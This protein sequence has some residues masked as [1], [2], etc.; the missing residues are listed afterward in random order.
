MNQRHFLLILPFFFF[1]SAILGTAQTKVEHQ[2]VATSVSTD[3]RFF[4]YLT[5]NDGFSRNSIHA[6]LQDKYGFMWFLLWDGLYRFDGK[7]LTHI[8]ATNFQKQGK[9]R[10]INTFVSDGNGNIWMGTTDNIVIWDAAQQ[11]VIDFKDKTEEGKIFAGAVNKLKRDRYNN[12]W[13][14]NKNRNIVIYNQQQGEF[15]DISDILKG[16]DIKIQNIYIDHQDQVWITTSA[17]GVFQ[18]KG[19]GTN[20]NP[21]Y[22]NQWKLFENPLFKSFEDRNV[23][24]MY[25]DSHNHYWLGTKR[26]IFRVAPAAE[27]KA[28]VVYQFENWDKKNKHIRISDFEE[29]NHT[30]YGAT[31]QGLFTF[32]FNTEKAEWKLPDYT[33]ENRLNDKSLTSICID[34]ENGMWIA[35]Y[36]GGVNYMHPTNKNFVQF[37]DLNKNIQGHVISGITEDKNGNIWMAVEDNG[38][39]LWNRKT[40]TIQNFNHNSQTVYH[41]SWHNVQSIY[42]DGNFLY[43]GMF[44]GGLDIV[45]LDNYSH[46]NLNQRNTHPSALPNNIYSFHKLNEKTL[47][48][49]TLNGLFEL[50]TQNH[51]TRRIK[52]IEGKVNCI[53]QDEAGDL[54]VSTLSEG[55]YWHQQTN[56]QW[57]QFK[58]SS[59]DS[60]QNI[61]NSITTIYPLNPSIFVGTQGNGL[62]VFNKTTQTAEPVAPKIFRKSII[63]NIIQKGEIL[64]ITTNKGLF[65]YNITNQQTK[66]YTLQD[67]LR[68]NQFKENSGITTSDNAIIIGGLNGFNYFKPTLLS[69]NQVMPEVILT[70]FYLFNQSANI[71]DEDSPLK[72]S[73]T[74]T[75]HLDLNQKHHSFSFKF[76][77]TSYCDPSKNKFEYKLEPFEKDW[78]H[79]HGSSNMAN[80]TNLPSGEYIFHVRTSNGEGIWSKEKCISVTIHPYWWLSWPMKVLYLFLLIGII[81]HFILRYRNKKRE[82]MR[83]FRMEKDKEVYESKM[84]F[85]TCMVHEIRTPLTLILGPL[86]NAMKKEKEVKEV[87]PDLQIIERN[88]KRLLTLVNQLMDFRKIEDKSYVAQL[89]AVNI[90]ELIHQIAKDFHYYNIRKEVNF[91]Y[92]LPEEECW[93][94]LDRE[95]FT[96]VMVNLLSNA[97]K[98]T[99][100]H[101]KIELSRTPDGK[102]WQTSVQ[103]NGKGIPVEE[104]NAIFESFYQVHQDLPG[105]F[106]GTGIGLFVV[107]RLQK[108]QHGDIRVESESG[109]G[110]NFIITNLLAEAPVQ[111]KDGADEEKTEI[112]EPQPKKDDQTS[113]SGNQKKRLLIAEDN[114]EMRKYITSLFTEKYEVDSCENGKKALE[115]TVSQNYDLIITDLMMPVM[116]GMTL[117]RTL[118]KQGN[119]CHIPIIILTAKDDENSQMEGYESEADMYVTKPFSAEVLQS[120][121]KSILRN[122]EHLR[123]K[124]FTEPET[125]A[126]VFYTND[127]DKDFLEK[128]D[129]IINQKLSDC[130]IPIDEVATEMA[131]GRS[132]FYQKVKGVTGLTPNDYIRTYRLKKAVTLFQKGE[133]RINEVCYRVGFSSPSYFTKRFSQQFGISPSDY[134]KKNKNEE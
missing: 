72:Q 76:S 95:G 71:H 92:V 96:K 112:Q 100:D 48:V 67:G 84:R 6:I 44:I 3:M 70:D 102:Y 93:A 34:R 128:L 19:D 108:L 127:S 31:N 7:N 122:R 110:A 8:E 47:L 55:F 9:H 41:P 28:P 20:K 53:A 116:D 106:V 101:I 113:I 131:M 82:E 51:E 81:A 29:Y 105:D 27:G 90:K 13:I 117:C 42:A 35:S 83:I 37:I 88:G 16:K 12:I 14:L 26:A 80:Y 119:T 78:Q 59:T 39:C 66:Q 124:F 86:N 89:T 30:L 50:N 4:N 23:V 87:L 125:T 115:A 17:N 118:K 38:I 130:N 61:D 21:F 77:S 46:V 109:K 63:F 22:C 40:N 120:R 54:W 25:Q 133:T 123:H 94:T 132:T 10:N 15:K 99:K 45:N 69:N 11:R 114:E 43:V 107:K 104:Q 36:Y 85:F 98:F 52:G 62:W 126:E 24:E 57:H 103:D 49:G 74:C 18:L 97:M 33:E 121:V 134:L 60:T 75:D 1:L 56:N 73:I 111:E 79:T 129:Q 91:E 68:S 2:T 58:A 32:D 5:V 64:W 65:A